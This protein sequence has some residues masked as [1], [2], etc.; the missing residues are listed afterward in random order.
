[1]VLLKVICWTI[2]FV[3]RLHFPPGTSIAMIPTE[4]FLEKDLVNLKSTFLSNSCPERLL[5]KLFD[6]NKNNKK[7][8]GPEKC[9]VYLKLLWVG[10]I[11]EIFFE[12]ALKNATEKT[13]FSTKLYCIF[14]IR[15]ILPPTPKD[16]LPAFSSSWI[17]YDFKCQVWFS[18]CR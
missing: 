6:Y 5:D 2:I 11:S 4:K 7:F 18:I 17:V 16:S 12:K 8:I 15:T 1:M 10:D 13:F 14:S 9:P 3:I